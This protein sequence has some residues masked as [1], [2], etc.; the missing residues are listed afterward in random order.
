MRVN[1][2][3]D[4]DY[5]LE[6]ASEIYERNPYRKPEE[7][8][9]FVDYED[10]HTKNFVRNVRKTPKEVRK[11]GRTIYSNVACLEL[12]SYITTRF[13]WRWEIITPRHFP[14]GAESVVEWNLWEQYCELNKLDKID[15]IQPEE[16]WF[17]CYTSWSYEK[18]TEHFSKTWGTARI[19]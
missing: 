4:W 16:C 12:P 13:E 17:C 1:F 11:N 10:E 18:L 19:K 3:A 14:V 5:L 15:V 8:Y 6:R 7:G 2:E 9:T